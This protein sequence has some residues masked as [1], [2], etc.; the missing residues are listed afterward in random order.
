MSDRAAVTIRAAVELE[1]VYLKG[2]LH[3]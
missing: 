1:R 2:A 3:D